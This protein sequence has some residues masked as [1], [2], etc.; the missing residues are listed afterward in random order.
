MKDGNF[1]KPGGTYTFGLLTHKL[2]FEGP[3]K[4]NRSSYL[5]SF[6]RSIYDL[7][8]RAYG[9]LNGGQCQAV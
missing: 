5:I 6:R 1:Y 3:V 8:T 9:Y 7:F 4:P 2:T